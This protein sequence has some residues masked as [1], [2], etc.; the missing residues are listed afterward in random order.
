MRRRIV[1]AGFTTLALMATAAQAQQNSATPPPVRQI[2]N[3]TALSRDTLASVTAAVEAGGKVYVNDISARRLLMFDADLSRATV[4]ADSDAASSSSYGN[5]PGTLLP[6]RGDSA[7]F[8]TPASMS[9]LV[10]NPSGQVARV[11]AMPPSGGGIMGLIGNI[12]GTPG[13]DGRGRLAYFSPVRMVF[14]NRG[15]GAPPD[16][17][18][19][20]PPD[21]AYVVRFDFA[22]RTIDTAAVIKIPRTSTTVTRGEDGSMR[23]VMAAMPPQT[24]D[25]WAVTSDGRV[26]VV[27]GRDYHVDYL[28]TDGTWSNAPRMP[29]SWERLDDE[30]K[31]RLIDSAQTFMQAMID[32][33]QARMQREGAGG[34]AAPGAVGARGGAQPQMGGMMI[35]TEGGPAGGGGGPP[36]TM[37]MAPPTVIK[38]ELSAVPDYRPAFGQ[39]SVRADREGNLWIRTTTVLDGRPVYDIVNARGELTERVQLPAFRTI[40]GFGNG[41]V[42][43]GVRDSNGTVHLERARIH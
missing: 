7:L 37:S 40:A 39:G 2:T 25:D 8:I 4:V 43:M 31:Q 16:R 32:S 29:Y 22:G 27:R 15:G 30:M 5:R 6:Y 38:A 21:S 20:Q 9:M 14:Q 42:Y 11:M 17:M 3:V 1:P 19:L 10:L 24:V 13:F 36:R 18:N 41:V 26:A 12:F 34:A 33:N 35:V 28:N 23:A